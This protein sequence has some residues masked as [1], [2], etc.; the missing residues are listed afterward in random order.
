MLTTGHGTLVV[1]ILAAFA[2]GCSS[3]DS[4]GA[5][6]ST[7]AGVD[8]IEE[9]S[10]D[11]PVEATADVTVEDADDAAEVDPIATVTILH[12]GEERGRLLPELR[13]TKVLG[14]A[15]NIA[16]RWKDLEG[17]TPKTH[18]VL[19]SG[20]SWLGS[21][22]ATW[23]EGE[24]VVAAMNLMGYRSV[25]LGPRDYDFG[26]DAL[27]Q[28]INEADFSFVSAN[29][30]DTDTGAVVD[31]VTP[32]EVFTVDGVKVA[33]I[34][35]MDVEQDVNPA[36]VSDLSF[37]DY[38]LTLE[39][40]AF[41]ARAK[42]ANVVVALTSGQFSDLSVALDTLSAPVDVVF[43]GRAADDEGTS[44]FHG[45]V[46]LIRSGRHWLGYHR[47]QIDFDRVAGQVIGRKVDWVAVEYEQAD[48]NP[49]VPDPNVEAMVTQWEASAEEELG[50][51]IGYLEASVETK[52]WTMAN[53]LVDA[54]LWSFPEAEM[55]IQN[56]GGLKVSVGPGPI[57]IGQLVAAFPHENYIYKTTMTG[58]DVVSGLNSMVDYCETV[59]VTCFPVVA[60]IRYDETA[61]DLAVELADGTPIDLAASYTVLINSY[62][63][64]GGSGIPYDPDL[65]IVKTGLHMRD[66]VIA[67]TEQLNT[68][69]ADPLD[70]YLD[71]I[72]RNL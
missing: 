69:P 1:V 40:F 15:A 27:E 32:Y 61:P 43:A 65:E 13:G 42:G 57:T 59:S 71:P 49:V 5:D 10:T 31:Y 44:E 60:G 54:W 47:V 29:T 51:E 30:L 26:R 55:A 7:D 72:P 50:Q 45:E 18:L 35:L 38:A 33:V 8:A 63:Y 16:A 46:P 66:P 9:A 28:R 23:L 17:Y 56:S 62:I 53:W 48:G 34:G 21:A 67:W 3:E 41:E 37:A 70:N 12:T 52:S 14:G 20:D 22:S 64:G 11:A 68:S 24:N 19:S 4:S 39:Q 25:T 6:G 36:D 2:M 58:A